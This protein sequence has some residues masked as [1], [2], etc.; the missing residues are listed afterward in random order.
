M[1]ERGSIH[2]NGDHRSN[3]WL[4]AL[5]LTMLWLG[6][7][8]L[9]AQEGSRASIAAT[10]VPGNGAPTR[11]AAQCDPANSFRIYR[12]AGGFKQPP[13]EAT[14]EDSSQSAPPV[15]ERDSS[16]PVFFAD[17]VWADPA[18]PVAA[19]DLGATPAFAQVLDGFS[20]R[21]QHRLGTPV[22]CAMVLCQGSCANSDAPCELSGSWQGESAGCA[23]MPAGAE[24]SCVA[25]EGC[26]GAY[27]AC[28]AAHDCC[29]GGHDACPA[30]HDCCA[31]KGEKCAGHSDG[32]A[33]KH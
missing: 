6:C 29:A 5:L 1:S 9:F 8:P 22:T 2:C 30:A 26:A 28:P 24:E 33:G 20:A 23:A 31:G 32:C 10:A 7:Q 14:A 19:A 11:E 27:D 15:E 13:S 17:R 21:W 18:A 25:H 12:P 16:G 4:L 3:W